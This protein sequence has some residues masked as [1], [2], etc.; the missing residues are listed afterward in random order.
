MPYLS[1]E[2]NI[3][4][5]ENQQKDLMEA[6]SRLIVDKM[7][8]PQGYTMVS[9]GETKRILFAGT[10]EAAAFVQLRAINLPADQCGDLSKEICALLEKYCCIKPERVF[11]NFSD[12]PAKL[13]GYNRTTFG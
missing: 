3:S 4:L 6:A 11:I 13:W 5:S 12:I 7:K 10:E 1:I 2:T 8:K 9:Y